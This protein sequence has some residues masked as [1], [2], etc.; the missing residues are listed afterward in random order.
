[1]NSEYMFNNALF[2]LNDKTVLDIFF[3]ENKRSK[4]KLAHTCI[5]LA[6]VM[7][8]HCK[9]VKMNMQVFMHWPV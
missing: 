1:M 7:R 2:F 5:L 6:V 3:I 4:Y 8:I 9:H